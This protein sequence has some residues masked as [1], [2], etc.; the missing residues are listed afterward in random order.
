MTKSLTPRAIAGLDRQP[1][2][3][4]C[5]R[6]RTTHTDDHRDRRF[7]RGNLTAS[8]EACRGIL[9]ARLGLGPGQLRA[10]RSSSER[11]T[12]G[13]VVAGSDGRLTAA[14]TDLVRSHVHGQRSRLLTVAD[15]MDTRAQFSVTRERR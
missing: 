11:G 15:F 7:A 2:T 5:Q 8:A 12:P 4:R 9:R 13:L 1:A 6:R 3:L 10:E 14:P